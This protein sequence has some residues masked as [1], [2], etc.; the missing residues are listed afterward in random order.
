M[1]WKLLRS[2]IS[3][4]Q[5]TAYAAANIVGLFIVGVGLQ[6]GFD[7]KASRH[8]GTDP[9]S[10]TGRVIVGIQSSGSLFD[11]RQ[12]EIDSQL[13]GEISSQPWSKGVEPILPAGFDINIGIDFGGRGFTTAL[14]MEGISDSSLGEIPSGWTF[15]SATPSA[16]IILPADYLALYNFGFAPAR[17]LPR[18]SER[19]I[20]SL[21]LKVTFSG[22]GI[23]RTI[24]GRVVG[25]SSNIN[26]IAVPTELIQWGNENFA[27][28]NKVKIQRAI[29]E[30]SDPGNPAITKWLKAHK[31]DAQNTDGSTS[32]LRSLLRL[33]TIGIAGIGALISLLSVG[34]LLLSVYLLLQKNRAMLADLLLLGY[35]PK[36]LSRPYIIMIDLVNL[37]VTA[38]VI[39]GVSLASSAWSKPLHELG[40]TTASPGWSGCIIVGIGVILSLLSSWIVISRIRGLLGPRK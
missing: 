4:W 17:G 36:E 34:L 33:L 21:P 12:R 5:I 9:F 31:L 25:F 32:R 15:D 20:S 26:T 7:L 39:L 16:A 38:I 6:F 24:P 14:F 29:I 1:L 2:N 3:T 10:S 40:M 8:Q 22:N 37:A 35:E 27:D 13:L 19:A 30:L 18:L 23:S 11:F 28:G